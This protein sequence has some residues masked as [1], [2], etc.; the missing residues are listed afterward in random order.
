MNKNPFLLEIVREKLYNN[1]WIFVGK[2]AV[3]FMEN[4]KGFLQ[5]VRDVLTGKKLINNE[6]KYRFI[7][8]STA[9]VHLIFCICMRMIHVDFLYYYNICIVIFYCYMAIVLVSK[10]RYRL[11][12]ILFY[13]EVELYAGLATFLVG[14]DYN[15]LLYTVS[16]VPAAFYLTYSP[17]EKQNSHGYRQTLI[18]SMVVVICYFGLSVMGDEVRPMYDTS[19]YSAVKVV[20]RFF[21]IFIAFFI[22]FVF[23]LFFAMEAGYM[24]R[25]LEKENV[26]LGEEASYDPLTNLLNR[27]SLTGFVTEEIGTMEHNDLFSVVMMDI[28]NFKTVNDTY[29][30]DVGDEVLVKLASI[31]RDE[32]REGDYACRW[33]GEEFLLFSHGSKYDTSHAAERIRQRFAESEF[34]DKNGNVFKVTITMGVAEY[35]YGMQFRNIVEIADKRLYHG[36]T[37][38]KNQVV[39]D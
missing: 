4:S 10:E 9:I 31:I 25:L 27:R 32:I 19:A 18:L 24:S 20:I 13:A 29:G 22:Q 2:R 12:V 1:E 17:T 21:N 39:A 33:G 28:D 38:G 36:K 8:F 35:R 16:L 5:D 30:H 11:I 34:N 37:H 26:K 3:Y 7:C 14:A 6:I 15:F 23:S